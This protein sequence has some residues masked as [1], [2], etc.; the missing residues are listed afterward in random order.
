VNTQKAAIGFAEFVALIAALTALNAL[1]IDAMLPALPQIGASLHVATD[2]DRQW[3]ITAYLLG[4]SSTQL[5]YGVLADRFGRKPVLLTGVGLY[6]VFAVA[7]AFATS[8]PQLVL[9]R[10][11]MGAGAAAVQVLAVS[12]VRDRF[13]GAQMA[14][15]MSLT[16]MVF[17]TAPVLAPSIGQAIMVVSSWRMIFGFLAAFSLVLLTWASLRLPET[18][19]V[20]DRLPLEV[21]RIAQAFRTVL[22]SRITVGY[23]L[24]AACVLGGLFG[25]INSVQQVFTDIFHAPT[26]FPAIFACIAIGMAAASLLNAR[27]VERLGVRYVS[28]RA[29][30]GFIT[31]GALHWLVA[32]NGYESIATFAVLQGAMMFCF[33][34]VAANFASIAMEPLGHVAGTGSSIYGSITMAVGSTLGFVIG[35]QFDGTAVPL[36]TGYVLCGLLALAIVL[37][38]ERGALFGAARASVPEAG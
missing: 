6:A 11:L 23:M 13:A 28:H 38:T 29:L 31:F 16:F 4:V 3:V 26:I 27:I 37:I 25:F 33:G 19:R 8:F 7:A 17:L 9:A 35:Q 1:A 34:M 20:E 2:N 18:L 36:T 30:L 15:V 14:R 22:R 10:G 5:I 24:A 21:G 32:R 12:L